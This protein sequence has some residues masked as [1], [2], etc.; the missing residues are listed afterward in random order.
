MIRILLVDDRPGILSSFKEEFEDVYQIDTFERGTDALIHLEQNIGVYDMIISDQ[1]MELDLSGAEFLIAARKLEPSIPF[2]AYTAYTE[3]QMLSDCLIKAQTYTLLQK[4]MCWDEVGAKIDAAISAYKVK[5]GNKEKLREWIDYRQ[6]LVMAARKKV[7]ASL[8]EH[9][10]I[11]M[12]AELE[13]KSAES[14]PF[15][16]I[17]DVYFYDKQ[18][19]SNF[20]QSVVGY[21]DEYIETPQNENIEQFR[22]ITSSVV[23]FDSETARKHGVL[24]ANILLSE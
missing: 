15:E 16:T 17:D 13:S 3:A 12:W 2:A 7:I 9:S 22:N 6:E 14:I 23:D 1:I 19:E 20:I 18:R 11:D 8:F 24:I 5:L 21:A 4:T 10:S